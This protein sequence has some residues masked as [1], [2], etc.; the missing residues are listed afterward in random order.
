MYKLFHEN[1]ITNNHYIIITILSN[2][3]NWFL[4]RVTI[5]WILFFLHYNKHSAFVIQ[6]LIS[7]H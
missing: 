6:V 1:N 2:N 3:L 4:W 7:P 5:D